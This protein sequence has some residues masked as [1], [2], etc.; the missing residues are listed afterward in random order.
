MAKKS[1]HIWI[2]FGIIALVITIKSNPNLFAF[3]DPLSNTMPNSDV[4]SW[5]GALP[6]GWSTGGWS[7]GA[8]WR[9]LNQ[10]TVAKS[11]P[12]SAAFLNKGYNGILA[13]TPC[14]DWC[15]WETGKAPVSPSSITRARFYINP[16]SF[17]RY[18]SSDGIRTGINYYDSAGIYI[19][20]TGG[21]VLKEAD[22]IGVGLWKEIIIEGISPPGAATAAVQFTFATRT[23]NQFV[24]S[25]YTDD[26]WI[27]STS[28]TE[29]WVCGDYTYCSGGYQERTCTDTN[30]C[31]TTFNK[32]SASRSCEAPI[33]KHIQD[34]KTNLINIPS[35]MQEI[36]LWRESYISNEKLE[37]MYN[38][39]RYSSRSDGWDYSWH[40]SE[41][42]MGWE[43][44]MAIS[45]MLT[46]Y[47]TTGKTSYLELAIKH[48]DYE[49]TLWP[50]EGANW[51]GAYDPTVPDSP[52]RDRASGG[53]L[54]ENYV[55]FAYIVKRDGL[56][57]YNAKAETYYTFINDHFIQYWN[58][59]VR[60]FNLDGIDMG[61]VADGGQNAVWGC[62]RYNAAAQVATSLLY[63]DLYKPNIEYK[64]NAIKMATYFKQ[65]A[66]HFKDSCVGSGSTYAWGYR[67]YTGLPGD[68]NVNAWGQYEAGH[69][70]ETHYSVYDVRLI[71]D[72]WSHGLV[73]TD[74]D[75]EI[76][77]RTFVN[78]MWNHDY[79]EPYTRSQVTCWS[80]TNF[81]DNHKGFET[82]YIHGWTNYNQFN[83]TMKAVTERIIKKSYDDSIAKNN[84]WSTYY[85]CIN[86]PYVGKSCYS[87]MRTQPEMQM[88]SIADALKARKELN[89]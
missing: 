65:K 55:R 40:R 80:Y 30:A 33:E 21:P 22:F 24:A 61:C 54:A 35:L 2:L 19:A 44:A 66:L 86:Q 79:S 26:F 17:M 13:E 53:N 48:I 87:D 39:A 78:N 9:D 67:Y 36:K 7:H 70:E 57:Q 31:G 12:Y 74:Q 3:D 32:P 43:D 84:F 64:N 8:N 73:F 71:Y 27:E 58:R 49:I 62:D 52:A 72:F 76:V 75:M 5:T 83:P 88:L 81:T 46:M 41:L 1:K 38:R 85:Q 16:I 45:S 23:D 68:Q 20:G 69:T 37:A 34:Y 11:T 56:T 4:T 63:A 50:F 18:S 59:D 15:K 51:G 10:S 6:T 89:Q 47:E 29:N 60:Q 28:C 42:Y 25:F 77:A 82:G 14:D